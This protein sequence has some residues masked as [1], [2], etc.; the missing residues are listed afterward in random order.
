MFYLFNRFLLAKNKPKQLI[1]H[2]VVSD[3][4]YALKELQNRNWPYFIDRIIEYSQGF[5]DLEELGISDRH[6]AAILYNTTGNFNILEERYNE[7]YNSVGVSLHELLRYIPLEEKDRIDGDLTNN[8]YFTWDPY[9]DFIQEQ[10]LET[11]RDFFLP[12]RSFSWLQQHNFYPSCPNSEF[13]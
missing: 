9:Q 1:R 12:N 11:Y 2:R 8:G 6:E 3:D 10:I 5:K 7:L 13:Y 4:N